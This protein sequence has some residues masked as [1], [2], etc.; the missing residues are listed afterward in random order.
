[1]VA[2][3]TP[4][5]LPPPDPDPWPTRSIKEHGNDKL[6]YW[7][8]ILYAFSIATR[9]DWEGNRCCLDLFASF[10]INEDGRGERSWGS[11][12]L[13]LLVPPIPFDTYVFADRDHKA[14]DVLAKRVEAL[15]IAGLEIFRISLRDS[16]A[17]FE[18][19]RQAK[20]ARTR[21]PKVA[22]LTGD[23]NHAPIVA[24]QL[25]PAFSGQ[26]VSLALIDP[27]GAHFSWEAMVNLTAYER[28]DLLLLFP[29]DMDIER[30]LKNPTDIAR[31]NRYFGSTDW[32]RLRNHPG[33]RGLAARQ[34]YERRLK[35]LGYKLGFAKT[36]RHS[37]N[38]P[39]YRLIFGSK[40]KL[41]VKIWNES[42]QGPDGQYGM[43]FPGI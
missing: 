1:M 12:L 5:D 21:G 29:E 35:G 38:A 13:S 41:G 3:R 26:R 10:G 15:Q 25:L 20:A 37:G 34:Y 30:N 19:A 43:Y 31:L 11:A 18:Q 4:N 17:A 40:S 28:M 8:S 36:V 22:I 16:D 32:Q 39:I 2:L 7:A 9:Y 27:P 42:R 14:T 33:D 24:R 6:F 23:A